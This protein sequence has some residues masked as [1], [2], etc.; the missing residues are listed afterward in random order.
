MIP[1]V[2]P[3]DLPQWFTQTAQSTEAAE[4]WVLDVREPWELQ[5]ASVQAQGFKLVHIPMNAVPARL[6]ELPT[7]HPIAVLCHHGGRSAQV[8]F[9]L[10]S[11]GYEHIANIHGGIHLWSQEV[12][13]SIPQY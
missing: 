3:S 4:P 13:A 7:T 9:F 12:D 10:H 11:Q 8:A 2:R 1:H 6:N 5:T